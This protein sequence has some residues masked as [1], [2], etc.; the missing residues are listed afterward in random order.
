[1]WI[2][3]DKSGEAWCGEHQPYLAGTAVWFWKKNSNPK[4]AREFDAP[5]FV[6]DGWKETLRRMS[7]PAPTRAEQGKSLY[8]DLMQRLA[9]AVESGALPRDTFAILWGEP[10]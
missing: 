5:T 8:L 10:K 1:M 9:N 3:N 2:A 6:D 7:V 4:R